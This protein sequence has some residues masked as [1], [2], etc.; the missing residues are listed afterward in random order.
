MP[1]QRRIGVYPQRLSLPERGRNGKRNQQVGDPHKTYIL[2]FG[3][4]NVVSSLFR[5][6]WGD[7]DGSTDLF[8]S[9]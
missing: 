5:T 7:S 6:K 1:K 4:S 8:P 3:T 9:E 2:L